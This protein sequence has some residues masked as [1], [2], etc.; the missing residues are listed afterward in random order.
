MLQPV[1]P[2]PAISVRLRRFGER[3]VAEVDAA[4]PNV[5]VGLTARDALAAAL[6]PLGEATVA[7]LLADLSL[8]E[9]SLRLLELERAAS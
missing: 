4:G 1:P 3:W 2:L 8:L 9:P 5:A 6:S 7:L